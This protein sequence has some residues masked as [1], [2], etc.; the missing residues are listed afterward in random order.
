[1]PRLPAFVEWKEKY[2]S[3][4]FTNFITFYFLKVQWKVPGTTLGIWSEYCHLLRSALP[5]PSAV[6]QL[7]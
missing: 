4:I 2:A 7:A 3:E 6:L 5:K 1:M